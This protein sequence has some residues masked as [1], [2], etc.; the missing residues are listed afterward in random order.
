MIPVN[1]E[2]ADYNGASK[3]VAEKRKPGMP[4]FL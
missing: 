2:S 1:D 4:G 3:V